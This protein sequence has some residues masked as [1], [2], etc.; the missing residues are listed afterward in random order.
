MPRKPTSEEK[1][2]PRPKRP[3]KAASP[4]EPLAERLG[5][6]GA[7]ALAGS[8]RQSGQSRTKKEKQAV[9]L[10]A[11]PALDQAEVARLAHSYWLERGGQGGSAEEDW[12]RAEQ[13][14]RA[15]AASNQG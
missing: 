1:S 10:A 7:E 12:H 3:R 5:A 15:R 14:L 13:A 11:Q 9:A 2:K 8:E 4:A 6:S